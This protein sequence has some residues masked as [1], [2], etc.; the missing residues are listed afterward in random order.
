[1]RVE[2]AW[3]PDRIF[4]LGIMNNLGFLYFDQ[5]EMEKAEKILEKVLA[6][7]KK[8][9][10]VEHTSILKKLNNLRIMYKM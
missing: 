3:K 2:K 1:M 4:I 5:V 9:M 6:G 7:R 10:E 8:T